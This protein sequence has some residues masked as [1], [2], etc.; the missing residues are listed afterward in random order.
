[1]NSEE[2]FQ[3]V[4]RNSAEVITIGELKEVLKK[5]NPVVYLGT[6]ITGKPHAGYFVWVLKMADFLRAGFKVKLLLADLHGALDNTPW[7][8]LE[9]RYDYYSIVIKSLFEAVGVSVKNLEIVKGSSFQLKKDYVLDMFK[10][11]SKVSVHD[12]H[13]AASDVVKMG[14]NPK[15]SGLIYPVMQALDEEYL[16]VD[17]QYGGMDQRKIFVLARENLPKIEYKQRVEF[18]MPLI[19]GLS[20]GGKMSSSVEHSK[21]D[22]LDDGET[23][24]RKI[25]KAF[26]PEGVAE[27]N[28]VLALFR[29]V[30]MVM[31]EDKGKSLVIKRDKKFGGDLKISNY[32]ELEEL[33]SAKRIH[34][35]DLKN[36]LASELDKLVEPCRRAM[37]GK[38]KLIREAYP[39]T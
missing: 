36:C 14:D 3:L 34:P 33:Y 39:Q 37:K 28:G 32:S 1:M 23:I 35:M 22:L 38:E 21:I 12:C 20:E 4:M 17:V 8:L 10:L 18:V 9:K 2:R 6:S 31:K 24:K 13:K 15:L 27:N 7:E 11:A 5:K 16:N 30:V 19:P 29:Y 25:S 26:C